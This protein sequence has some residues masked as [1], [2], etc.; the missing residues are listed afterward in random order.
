MQQLVIQG[1][2]KQKEQ[3]TPHTTNTVKL[4]KLEI[5]C[6]TVDVLNFPEFSDSF[7]VCVHSN[8]RLAGEIHLP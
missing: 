7:E 2:Q 3:S 1:E 4:P 8:T 5:P 6:F